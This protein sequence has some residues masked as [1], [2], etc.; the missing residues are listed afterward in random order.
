MLITTTENVH[1]HRVLDVKG[2][3]FGVVVRSRG[4]GGRDSPT[5]VTFARP[6]PL[7]W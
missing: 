2:E 6:L 5:L 3:V 4:I 7:S 1:G